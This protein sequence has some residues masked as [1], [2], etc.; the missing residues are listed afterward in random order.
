MGISVNGP[1]GIDTQYIIDS[2]IDLEKNKVRAVEARKEA[3]Q[4][5]IDAYSKLKTLLTDMAS[6]VTS[7]G[8]TSDFDIFKTNSSN[9]NMVTITGGAGSVDAR[10]DVGVFQLASNEKMITADGLITDQTATLSSLGIGAGD[11]SIDGVE[12]TVGADDTLQD[13]R[14][15]INSAT[16]ATGNRLG[17]TASV[18]KIADN[19]FRLVLSAKDSGSEGIAYSDVSGT[20]LQDLGIIVDAAGEKGSVTQVV[21]SDTNV[22]SAWNALADGKSMQFTGIDHA[23]KEVSATIVKRPGST[24]ADFLS[25]VE[26]TFHGMVDASFDGGSGALVLTDKVAGSSQLAVSS[27]I[28]EDNPTP[29]TFSTAYGDEGGGVLS[30]GKDSFFSVE[31]IFMSN[32]SNSATGFVEG[33]SFEFHGISDELTSVS[34]DRDT[35]GIQEKFQDMLDAYNALVRFSKTNTKVGDPT[36]DDSSSGALAGD[37]TVRSVVSRINAVLHQEFDELG[38]TYSNFIMAGLKTDTQSGE[39]QVDGD[40]FKKAITD[41]FDDVVNLF[42]SIGVSDNS[43]VVMG[44]NTSDTKAGRYVVEEVDDQTFRARE[45]SGSTWYTSVARQGEIISFEDGPLN[46]LSLTAPVGSIGIG[47]TASFIFSKGLASVLEDSLS[48]LTDDREGL[49]TMRQES[50]KLSI[51]ANEDKIIDL[52]A[53]VEAY[54]VRLVK[55]FS[56]MEQALSKMQS[57]SSYMSSALSSFN[58]NN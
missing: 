31:N 21:T 32:S 43:N 3:D 37:M 44:R 56:D 54:R 45:E 39:L 1:S 48:K 42:T 4:V 33:V 13:L 2:L 19:N 15:K 58:S 30:V 27:M 20:T 35:D 46:G 9:E 23:G 24:D 29:V 16:D 53:R 17:V 51:R 47:N 28:L 40:M 12:I 8:K 22:Q 18:L 6:R 7:L 10:Y 49:V 38:G 36:D 26:K 11:I 50:W 55:Q 5:K 41:H 25:E 57:Q 14:Q 52:N 34:L